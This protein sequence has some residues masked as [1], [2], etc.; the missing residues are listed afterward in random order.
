MIENG[1]QEASYDMPMQYADDYGFWAYKSSWEGKKVG[2]N[3][4][5]NPYST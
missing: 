4:L 5:N 2:R 3:I 1:I